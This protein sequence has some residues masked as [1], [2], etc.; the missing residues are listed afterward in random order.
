MTS[1][2][3]GSLN[4]PCIK[5]LLCMTKNTTHQTPFKRTFPHMMKKKVNQRCV[6]K[7]VRIQ[8]SSKRESSTTQHNIK[9]VQIILELIIYSKILS[10]S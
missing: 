3:R 4:F 7:K 8:L 2:D 10:N 9:R 1:L 6:L 5:E